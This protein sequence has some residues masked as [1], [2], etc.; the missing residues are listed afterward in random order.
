MASA[1]LIAWN[2]GGPSLKTLESAYA[3]YRIT[4]GSARPLGPDYSDPALVF[5][6]NNEQA[7][8]LDGSE[9]PKRSPYIERMQQLL[10]EEPD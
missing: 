6:V 3:D 7:S 2:V 1:A 8:L 9:P 4:T 5:L 10:L